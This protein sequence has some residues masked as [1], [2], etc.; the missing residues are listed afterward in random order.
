MMP[1]D[2]LE[3]EPIAEDIELGTVQ[4]V[5]D[6]NYDPTNKEICKEDPK[7]LFYKSSDFCNLLYRE[8]N[9]SEVV[10]LN[11]RRN[12]NSCS[13]ALQIYFGSDDNA[14]HVNPLIFQNQDYDEFSLTNAKTT[15]S[16]YY[17]VPR[18]GRYNVP[19]I[20]QI[21]YVGQRVHSLDFYPVWLLENNSEF[22]EVVTNR[23]NVNL[24][25]ISTSIG[26]ESCNAHIYASSVN[27]PTDLF[28]HNDLQFD[29]LRPFDKAFIS[30]HELLLITHHA[31]YL[32]ICGSRVSSGN[33]V[34]QELN[35]DGTTLSLRD[36]NK[37][38]FTYRLVG[39]NEIICS[40]LDTINDSDE[41]ENDIL[42]F[43]QSGYREDQDDFDPAIPNE[44]WTTPCPPSWRP[45]TP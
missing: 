11:S 1:D 42:G 31:R 39:F 8:F 4:P 18:G 25:A 23:V 38:Y 9:V 29:Y 24:D 2:N 45:T 10:A 19:P 30:R 20:S 35:P 12:N 32:G 26:T 34:A 5:I 6:P 37:N 21:E 33:F 14:S 16:G 17:I 28:N 41:F 36:C 22:I 43:I 40:E 27:A 44:T 3:K 13:N 15:L 7:M